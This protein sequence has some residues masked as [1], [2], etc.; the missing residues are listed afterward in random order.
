MALKKGFGLDGFFV[1][2][3]FALVVVFSTYN[4]EG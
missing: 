2:F 3:L 1:R 4:P